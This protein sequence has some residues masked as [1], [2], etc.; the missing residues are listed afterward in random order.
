MVDVR[1]LQGVYTCVHITCVYTRSVILSQQLTQTD[2]K[3]AAQNLPN[4]E[5]RMFY[6]VAA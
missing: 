5:C 3:T 4:V 1:W 2:T 6:I